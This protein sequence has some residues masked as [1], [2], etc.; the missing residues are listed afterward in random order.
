MRASHIVLSLAA[1][2]ALL[3]PVS[4][5]SQSLDVTVGEAEGARVGITVANTYDFDVTLVNVRIAF[6]NID[7]SQ[8]FYFSAPGLVEELAP[9]ASWE[10]PLVFAAADGSAPPEDVDWGNYDR[11]SA[12][13][14]VDLDALEAEA[15]AALDDGDVTAMREQLAIVRSRVAPVSRS[16]RFHGDQLAGSG[17]PVARWFNLERIDGMVER[18]EQAICAEASARYLRTRASAQ[19]E[20]YATLGG[21]LR[22]VDLHINCLSTE[23]K[24]AAAAA[25]IRNERAQDALVLVERVDGVPTEAW[26]GIFIQGSLALAQTA[27]AL[28]VTAFTSIRPALQALND[29]HAI[30]P[31]N[32]DLQR[33]A[34]TLIP[35]A[36]QWLITATE[37]MTRDLANAEIALQMLRPTWSRFEQIEEAAGRFA[38][39]M[40]DDGLEQCRTGNFVNSRN[41]F[42]RG[43]RILEG[44]PEWEA[45]AEEINRC[46]ALGALQEGRQIAGNVNDDNAPARGF[47]KLDEAQSRFDLE[48]SEIDAFKNDIADAWVAIA[49]RQ[50]DEERD[51]PG[52]IHSLGE[53]E[54]VAPNGRTD[55]IREAWLRYAEQLHAQY[56]M[57]MTGE[58]VDDAEAAIAKADGLD[59]DRISALEGKL[60][61]ARYG[62]RVGIP[63]GVIVL[64]LLG[65]LIAVLNRRKAAKLAAQLDELD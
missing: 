35:N 18:I 14:G 36:A 11:L 17:L 21:E 55:T 22:E 2:L 26:R 47:A 28:Q 65:V 19:P 31:E 52:A 58:Q 34:N 64:G 48:P 23:A 54:A 6:E 4:A 40:I 24:L 29:V 62:Y 46:R 9:G 43:E 42:D 8:T 27:A 7:G 32:A 45:R 56:G 44:V 12:A 57:L 50:I 15:Q 1:A 16:S 49:L 10:G 20:L 3:A 41:R 60:T 38:T 5:S 13:G 61:L 37:P 51:F 25:L 59:A 39:A 63:V 53:A 30:D 33:I